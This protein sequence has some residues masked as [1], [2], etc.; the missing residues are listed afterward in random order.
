MFHKTLH[1][2][3]AIA[4]LAAIYSPAA[5]AEWLTLFEPQQTGVNEVVAGDG[6]DAFSAFGCVECH[7]GISDQRYRSGFRVLEGEVVEQSIEA[8]MAAPYSPVMPSAQKLRLGSREYWP[9]DENSAVFLR[10]V[11]KGVLG[12]QPSLTLLNR[13]SQEEQDAVLD[14]VLMF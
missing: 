10:R 1:S 8:K 11:H 12:V 3:C 5:W 13:A 4:L 9:S 14:Y 7:S 6:R 2:F